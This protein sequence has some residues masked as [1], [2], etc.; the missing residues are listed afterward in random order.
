[1]TLLAAGARPAAACSAVEAMI[2]FPDRPGK[3][4]GLAY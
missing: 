3:T 4:N 2:V 1:M